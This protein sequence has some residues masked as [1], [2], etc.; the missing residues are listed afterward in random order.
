MDFADYNDKLRGFKGEVI[1]SHA[2]FC[3]KV[4]GFKPGERGIITNGKVDFHL[5][6]VILKL[7]KYSPIYVI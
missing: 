1:Q 5:V 7:R 2:A 3:S 4:L 6:P